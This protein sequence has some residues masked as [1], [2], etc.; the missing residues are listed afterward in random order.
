[1][2]VL[3]KRTKASEE[4][5][6]EVSPFLE[7]KRMADIE[8]Q[9]RHRAE[10]G[11]SSGGGSSSEES[12]DSEGDDR[13]SDSGEAEGSALLRKVKVVPTGADGKKALRAAREARKRAQAESLSAL[14]KRQAENN[15]AK[16]VMN[17]FYDAVGI[18]AEPDDADWLKL[19]H[20]DHN[21]G[22]TRDV[23]RVLLGISLLSTN[24]AEEKENGQGRSDPNLYP[25][26]T[27]PTGRM[28]FSTNPFV[29][30]KGL[31]MNKYMVMCC[32]CMCCVGT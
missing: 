2:Q 5:L 14:K 12:L 24:E 8:E 31:L 6:A 29:L 17:S 13:D 28:A 21:A 27:P 19:A 15:E 18:G 4:G 7:L 32:C 25:K 1:M 20:H 22:E 30:L 16:A 23:G 9:K 11:S 26:L 3:Y 10:H